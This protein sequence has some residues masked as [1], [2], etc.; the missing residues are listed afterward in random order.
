MLPIFTELRFPVFFDSRIPFRFS[1]DSTTSSFLIKLCAEYPPPCL[2]NSFTRRGEF[3][4]SVSRFTR[5]SHA[6][7]AYVDPLQ[8]RLR[9]FN[10]LHDPPL[11]LSYKPLNNSSIQLGQ[12]ASPASPLKSVSLECEHAWLNTFKPILLSVSHKFIAAIERL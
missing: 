6:C 7:H 2:F 10:L 12:P 11:S 8:L 5:V 4:W 3:L 9:N 1:S